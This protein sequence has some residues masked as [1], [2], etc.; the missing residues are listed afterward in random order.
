M[1]N[2]LNITGRFLSRNL[3]HFVARHTR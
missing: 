1:R 2:V 3:N